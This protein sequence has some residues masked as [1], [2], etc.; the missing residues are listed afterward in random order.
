MYR[1]FPIWLILMKVAQ[2]VFL[3]RTHTDLVSHGF[4]LDK[5]IDLIEGFHAIH[6]FPYVELETRATEADKGPF[7]A[8][9]EGGHL[10]KMALFTFSLKID[11]NIWNIP[12]IFF[13]NAQ[14]V[15]FISP[16]YIPTLE[17]IFFRIFFLPNK[18][19]VR[20]GHIYLI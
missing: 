3:Y 6:S 16:N 8:I 18:T 17:R 11:S 5:C 19:F 1:F 9:F 2:L 7:L 13:W 4:Y 14:Y 20:I 15:Y 10:M 12:T